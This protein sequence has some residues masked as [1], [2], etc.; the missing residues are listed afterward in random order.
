[1]IRRNAAAGR[2]H[3]TT[4]VERAAHFGTVQFIAVGTPPDEDGSADVRHVVAAARNIGRFMTDYKLV[5]DKSTGEL[6]GLHIIGPHASEMVHEGAI[7]LQRNG[8]AAELFATVHAH[9]TISE[10]VLEAVLGGVRL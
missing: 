4:D 5:V 2:L 1:M 9:P 3:F 6:I 8:K 10:G 7:V